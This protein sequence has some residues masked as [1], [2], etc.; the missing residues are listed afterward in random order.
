M[1]ANTQPLYNLYNLH[2]SSILRIT[3]LCQRTVC[4]V[5]YILDVAIYIVQCAERC[6]CHHINFA[7]LYPSIDRVMHIAV[8]SHDLVQY[9]RLLFHAFTSFGILPGHPLLH[10]HY[11]QHM[12]GF[13]FGC[14]D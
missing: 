4:V 8:F 10:S 5:L 13:H 14:H 2:I 1:I 6:R 7:L 9:G 12:N 3:V 11:M